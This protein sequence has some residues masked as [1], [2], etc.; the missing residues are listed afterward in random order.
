MNSGTHNNIVYFSSLLPERCPKTFKGLEEVL[1]RYGVEYRLLEGAKD[2]WVRDFMP[3]QVVP[4]VFE[5]FRYNPDYLQ[6]TA[7]HRASITDNY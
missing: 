4:H 6:D 3:I 2:I 5:L 1:S 7:Q